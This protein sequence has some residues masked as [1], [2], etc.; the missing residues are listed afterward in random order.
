MKGCVVELKV[1]D[2]QM[3]QCGAMSENDMPAYIVKSSFAFITACP[4]SYDSSSTLCVL[5]TVMVMSSKH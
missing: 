1:S 5:V 2:W 4:L 3:S